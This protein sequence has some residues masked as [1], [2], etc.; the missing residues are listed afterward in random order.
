MRR[1]CS[2]VRPAG[3][4]PPWRALLA[5]GA[6]A[7]LGCV[8]LP[9]GT[10]RDGV[11]ALVSWGCVAAVVVGV[12]RHRPRHAG[13][14]WCVAAGVASWAAGDLV[15]VVVA[16]VLHR[17]PFPSV[18]D[19]FYLLT[20]PLL[21]WGAWRFVRARGGARDRDGL[22]DSAIF[23]VGF[24]LL[25]WVF[26]VRPALGDVLA[27]PAARVVAAAYPV[28]DVLLLALLVRLLTTRGARNASFG[29]LAAAAGLTLL[30]DC[31]FQLLSLNGGDGE[32]V[33]D[34][35]WLAAYTCYGAAAL[36][37]SMRRTTD[38]QPATG[39]T[40][41]RGRLAAL[42]AASLLS[43]VTLM[44]QLALGLRLTG[45]AVACSSVALFLLVVWRMSG[46]VAHL[47]RQAVQLTALARTDALTGLAN[48]RSGDAELARMRA[49]AREDGTPLC[50]AVLDLDRFKAFNDT[51]GHQA[52]DQ[53][54]LQA[55]AAWSRE[56]DGS[57]AVLVRWGGEEFTVLLPGQDLD[58]AR[59]LVERLCAVTPAGQTFS[60]GVARWDGAESGD[61]LTA[62]ADEALYRAKAAG[63]ARVLLAADP[64]H[65]APPGPLP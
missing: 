47:Q 13:A 64:A 33:L 18:A 27:T 26:L 63:R 49:R 30:A 34:G 50:L 9:V 8:L 24:G 32:R 2:D 45:W 28:G 12:R 17:D 15:W 16:E 36:H 42:T 53:L 44:L 61:E 4:R 5:V 46:L 7:A 55:S 22:I 10:L 20:Y 39:V 25:M 23:T 38:R 56:L 29:L 65:R 54:L 21:A 48:R 14:W 62:R 59:A 6:V 3:L 52:G 11:Y 35:V 37:P 19:V 41:G 60:A 58:P 1:R 31:A 57:G 43:P 40:V 51:F